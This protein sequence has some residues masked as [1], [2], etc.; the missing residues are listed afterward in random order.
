MMTQADIEK[1]PEFDNHKLVKSVFD[2]ESG[3]R[4]VMAVH[5][6]NLGPGTGGTRMWVYVSEIDAVRD[7]LNLSRAMTYK[8]ALA[9]VPFGGSKGVIMGDSKKDKNE[10]LL[11]AYA[12]FINT[13]GGVTTGT[14]VGLNDQDVEIMRKTS[15]YIL[16]A[17]A[18]GKLSTSLMATMGVFHSI[19]GAAEEIWGSDDL[20]GRTF[21][22]KGLGKTGAELVRLLT[23][24]GG[25]IVAAEIDK[26]KIETIRKKYPSLIIVDESIIH[27]EAVDIYCPCALGGDLNEKNVKELRCQAIVGTANNQLASDIIGDWLH[28]HGFLYIPDYVANAGGLINVVDELETGGYRK[29]RVLERVAGIRVTVKKIIAGIDKFKRSTNRI[30][31]KMAEDVFL[32]S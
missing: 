11:T 1:L 12:E 27:K 18:E 10:K 28:E 4:A 15:K 32:R 2:E 29:E 24:R 22:V 9:G 5:N 25:K 7:A 14:D 13:L 31:D 3:L 23:E 30:A 26:E 16:G 19:L 8:C 17:P 20:S 6:E 21:A